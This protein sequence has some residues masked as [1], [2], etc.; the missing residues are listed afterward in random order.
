MY[1]WVRVGWR[2]RE[3]PHRYTLGSSSSGRLLSE[4]VLEIVFR[5]RSP[6]VGI[7][8]MC[9]KLTSLLVDAMV[10]GFCVCQDEIDAAEV[11]SVMQ[12]LDTK[13]SKEVSGLRQ[14]E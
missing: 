12:W 4:E 8:N 7:Q 14:I 3:L 10:R 5:L 2:P 11:F 1:F 9:L 13:V 6:L